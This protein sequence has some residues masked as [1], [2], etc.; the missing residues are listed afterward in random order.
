MKT[1]KKKDKSIN[2]KLMFLP[3]KYYSIT[4][5]PDDAHQYFGTTSRLT[6]ANNFMYEQIINYP[7]YG[8]QLQLY[9]ELSEP[10][11][12]TMSKNGPRVHWHGFL[13]MDDEKAVRNFLSN[14][15]YKLSRFS[16]FD[17]DTCDVEIWKRYCEKQQKII[18]F[19]KLQSNEFF[20]TQR[21]TLDNAKK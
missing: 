2:F 16:K 20:F 11:D 15:W 14:I 21:V 3:K 18:S 13:Y 9:M 5:N 7:I 17:I 4:I 1:N 12:N 10:M 6:R 8:T 19:K